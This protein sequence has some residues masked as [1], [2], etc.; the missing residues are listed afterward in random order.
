MSQSP[1]TSGPHGIVVRTSGPQGRSHNRQGL[2]GLIDDMVLG[3]VVLGVRLN[4][5]Y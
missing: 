2:V 1:K 3:L 4:R 5:D